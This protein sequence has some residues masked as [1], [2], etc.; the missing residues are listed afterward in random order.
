V[1][2]Y[3]FVSIRFPDGLSPEG[4]R[5]HGGRW[6]SKGI[7]ALYCSTSVAL[8]MLELR[9]HAPHPYPRARLKFVISVPDDAIV[10][11]KPAVLPDGWNRLPPG[12]TSKR[13]GDRW[14]A[15]GSGLGLLVPS[16]IAPEEKNLLLNPAH[17]RFGE[18]RVLTKERMQLD[19]RLYAAAG[20]RRSVRRA[21]D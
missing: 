15:A 18:V 6:N 8:A 20:T 1:K 7:A 14:L 10:E 11:A 16:V 19:S 2:V 21:R 5:Q 3:R 12:P 4:A 17:E 9:V 13:F